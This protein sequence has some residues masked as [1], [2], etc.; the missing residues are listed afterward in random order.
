MLIKSSA[1]TGKIFRISPSFCSKN[2]VDVIVFK[3][4]A[5]TPPSTPTYN[6]LFE[7]FKTVT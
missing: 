7:I 6:L 3:D 1:G 4:L 5:Q 2:V